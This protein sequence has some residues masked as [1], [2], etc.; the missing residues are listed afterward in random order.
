MLL[1]S[2]STLRESN[3]KL[4]E[5]CI[6]INICTPVSGSTVGYH[7]FKKQNCIIVMAL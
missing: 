7:G 4:T 5:L 1:T 2:T 6:I 3:T